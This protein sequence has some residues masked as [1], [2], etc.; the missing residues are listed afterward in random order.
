MVYQKKI[1]LDYKPS[2][3][4]DRAELKGTLKLNLGGLKTN[5]SQLVDSFSTMLENDDQIMNPDTEL[6][7]DTRTGRFSRDR[8]SLELISYAQQV[9]PPP[10]PVHPRLRFFYRRDKAQ[11]QHDIET[12]LSLKI[13]R[14]RNYGKDGADQ[15]SNRVYRITINGYG[16]KEVVYAMYKHLESITE[17]ENAA[18]LLPLNP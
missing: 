3:I 17:R 5:A 10:P 18:L 15:A 16:P 2:Q 13:N 1:K 9:P 8:A 7:L 11:N 14:W 4:E 12:K 6:H